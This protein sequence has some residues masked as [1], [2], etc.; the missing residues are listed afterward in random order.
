MG[1]SGRGV[2]VR[3]CSP[4]AP[5]TRDDCGFHRLMPPDLDLALGCGELKKAFLG[6]PVAHVT[7]GRASAATVKARK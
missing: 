5:E 3:G 6:R 2:W 7:Q 1:G 4:V